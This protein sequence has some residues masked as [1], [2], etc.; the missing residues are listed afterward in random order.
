MWLNPTIPQEAFLLAGH[1]TH[2]AY[3]AINSGKTTRGELCVYTTTVGAEMSR[4]LTLVD[5]EY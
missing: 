3:R 1:T 5:L 2:C 4:S